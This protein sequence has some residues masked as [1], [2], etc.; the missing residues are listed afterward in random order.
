MEAVCTALQRAA[1]VFRA[2]GMFDIVIPVR[3][4]DDAVA[5]CDA[6]ECAGVAARVVAIH[7]SYNAVQTCAEVAWNVR[8]EDLNSDEEYASLLA[9]T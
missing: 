8:I 6:L 3:R 4:Q 5:L 1:R 9:R 2:D 7:A